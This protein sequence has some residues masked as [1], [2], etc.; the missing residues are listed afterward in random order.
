MLTF[1]ADV[2]VRSSWMVSVFDGLRLRLQTD[3]VNDRVALDDRPAVLLDRDHVTV[4][5]CKRQASAP[6]DVP[7]DAEA[8][9][10]AARYPPAKTS[11]ATP[12][13]TTTFA[14]HGSRRC[15]RYLYQFES[16]HL[17]RK[18]LSRLPVQRV[19]MRGT[20]GRLAPERRYG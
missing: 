5:L 11:T 20:S 16:S 19:E 18:T 2:T 4:V 14:S 9:W 3:G 17:D 15:H 1:P 8:N 7:A 10:S 12:S 13:E 6:E